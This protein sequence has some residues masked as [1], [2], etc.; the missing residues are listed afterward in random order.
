MIALDWKIVYCKHLRF[1]ASDHH[2][3]SKRLYDII[4]VHRISVNKSL[5]AGVK[6]AEGLDTEAK[7]S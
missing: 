5:Y 7:V 3:R 4:R 1:N 6:K 2:C